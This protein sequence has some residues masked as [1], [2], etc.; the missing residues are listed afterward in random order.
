MNEKEKKQER[1][2]EIGNLINE[3]CNRY[4]NDELH[5]YA[6]KLLEKLTRKKTYSITSGKNEIMAKEAGLL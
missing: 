6:I 2:K 5:G 1:A 3:F 4:L